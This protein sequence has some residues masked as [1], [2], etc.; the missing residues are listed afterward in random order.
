MAGLIKVVLA[1]AHGEI[2]AQLHFRAPNPYIPWNELLLSVPVERLSWPR[3]GAKRLAGI[4]S[5]GISGTNCHLVLEEAPPAE[6]IDHSRK[7]V[8]PAYLL[9][10]SA[11][12]RC[13]P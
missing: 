13:P 5:F 4:S 6:P 3:G 12:K 10:M 1:L 7:I 11:K 9:S 8:R 2:P